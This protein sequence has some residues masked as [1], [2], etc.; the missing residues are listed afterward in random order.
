M[1]QSAGGERPF[2]LSKNR[3]FVTAG[4]PI[5]RGPGEQLGALFLLHHCFKDADC[6]LPLITLWQLPSG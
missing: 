4:G 5:W 2:F 1:L 6:T 3:I